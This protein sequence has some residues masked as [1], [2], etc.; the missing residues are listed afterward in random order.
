L[1]N[2]DGSHGL[3]RCD[4]TTLLRRPSFWL[5]SVWIGEWFVELDG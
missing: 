2:L 3:D 4:M 5:S 1:A